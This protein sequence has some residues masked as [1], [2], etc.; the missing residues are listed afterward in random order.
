MLMASLRM[1]LA[2]LKRAMDRV[3][4]MLSLNAVLTLLVFVFLP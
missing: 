3:T 4:W 2:G 1:E